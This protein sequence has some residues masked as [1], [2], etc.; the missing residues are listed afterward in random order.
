MTTIPKGNRSAATESPRSVSGGATAIRR[1]ATG[2]VRG[3]VAGAGVGPTHWK[4]VG[5][6]VCRET[7]IPGN[8]KASPCGG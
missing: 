8:K 1:G 6:M 5:I 2:E 4:R 3:Q 7:V